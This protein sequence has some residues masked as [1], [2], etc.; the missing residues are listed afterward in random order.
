MTCNEYINIYILLCIKYLISD[1][2]LSVNNA[3]AEL[4]DTNYN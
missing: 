4:D 2:R 1:S 3:V